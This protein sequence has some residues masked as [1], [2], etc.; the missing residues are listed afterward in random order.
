MRVLP[1]T[2]SLLCAGLLAA[3][4]SARADDELTPLARAID[5]APDDAKAYDNYA[6]K[7]IGA[8]R[9]DDAI[10]HLKSGVARIGDYPNGYYLL[11]YSYR[12][13]GVSD[14][15]A[16]A[17]AAVYYRMCVT[18]KFKESDAYFGLGKS[19]AGLGDNRAAA[20]ALKR[21]IAGEQRP[22]AQKFVEEAR[23]DL[24]RLEGTAADPAK[25]R[26]EADQLR[27]E[28]R[29]EE[30]AAA[31]RKAIDADKG[32]LD[33]YNDLGNVYYALKRYADAAAIFKAAT[34]RDPAYA[35]G[36]YNLA[37]NY[38]KGEKLDAAVDA[39]KRYLKLNPEDPDPYYG[40]GQT[41]KALGRTTDAAVSFRK[42]IE[43]EKR[44]DEQKW[45]EKARQEL[46]AI[47]ASQ[48]V[49]VPAEPAGKVTDEK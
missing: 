12:K 46:S 30:A 21:F 47:D 25:L 7:A 28:K 45:V 41:Q 17:D 36:W 29:F 37:L 16:F 39:Y 27:V 24:L 32:N 48:R 42:Y 33:L 23:A 6:L 8:G 4:A 11:A 40:L 13:K 19:L 35:M 22:T 15:A 1:I 3:S 10:A 14:K 20:V 2:S 44:P 43:M 31:Y 9:L 34:D 49:P 18:L 38:R 26:T 5:A